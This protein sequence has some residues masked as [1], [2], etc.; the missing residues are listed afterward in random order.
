MFVFT[1]PLYDRRRDR[2]EMGQLLLDSSAVIAKAKSIL[3]KEVTIRAAL[4]A[5][6]DYYRAETVARVGQFK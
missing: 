1:Y 6:R 5:V 4:N 2:V 3:G